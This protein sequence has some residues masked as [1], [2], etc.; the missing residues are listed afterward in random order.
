VVARRHD[1]AQASLLHRRVEDVLL[2]SAPHERRA[3]WRLRLR[4]PVDQLVHPGGTERSAERA[5]HQI[6]PRQAHNRP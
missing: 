3:R 5:G 1:D 4:Q 6:A 2:L